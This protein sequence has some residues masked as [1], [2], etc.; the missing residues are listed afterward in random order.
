ME[1]DTYVQEW[2]QSD[3]EAR[4]RG[5]G[6]EIIKSRAFVRKGGRYPLLSIL[7]RLREVLK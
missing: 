5:T 6:F 7:G 1:R 3:I 2:L 4:V